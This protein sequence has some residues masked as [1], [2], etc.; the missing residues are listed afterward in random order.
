MR[1]EPRF[2]D[3]DMQQLLLSKAHGVPSAAPRRFS[4]GNQLRWLPVLGKEIIKPGSHR[5]APF[6]G[7]D[8]KRKAVDAARAIR[9]ECL[10]EL[11]GEA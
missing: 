9:Q 4:P 10:D 7:Y 2:S 6:S 1:Q 11:A 3:H 5:L 8:T